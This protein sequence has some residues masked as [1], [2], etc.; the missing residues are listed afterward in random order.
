M[1]LRRIFI[2]GST[3]GLGRAAAQALM[4]QGYQVVLHAR[5]RERARAIAD[6][7]QWH[8]Q[9]RIIH[10]D[11]DAGANASFLAKPNTPPICGAQSYNGPASPCQLV[12][13]QRQ[14]LPRWRTAKAGLK[15]GQANEGFVDGIDF[16]VRREPAQASKINS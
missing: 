7:R 3:E 2:T 13:P 4:E 6:P 15:S 1:F 5:S 10:H 11:E 16:K 9:L 8:P 12:S 14:R